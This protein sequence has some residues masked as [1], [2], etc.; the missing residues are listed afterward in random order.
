MSSIIVTPNMSLTLP[1]PGQELGPQY[2]ADNNGCFTTLDAHDHSSGSGVPI[3]PAGMNINIDLPMNNYNL[4]LVKTVRFGAL[5]SSLAGTT[6]NLGCL[7]VAGNELYYNDEAGNVVPITLNGSVNAG[8]GSITGLPSGT[9]SASYSAGTFVWRSATNTP[10]NMDGGSFIFRQV[11]ASA[12]GVTVSSPNSL[13][14]DYSLVWPAA[15]PGSTSFATIDTSGNIAASISTT[16]GITPAMVSTTAGLNPPGA[17]IM[18]GGA[19]APTGWLLCDG[20]SYLRATYA[21]LFTAIS[22]AYGTVDGTHFNV[23]DMRGMFARGVTGASANDPDAS[24]RTANNTG[25]ATGNNVGSQQ[26]DGVRAHTHNIGMFQPS[27]T[28]TPGGQ[29]AS[30]N[31]GGSPTAVTTV[32]QTPASTGD[33]RPLNVYVNYII[34]T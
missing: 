29:V 18:Y 23:P 28:F 24:S 26:A 11:S 5:I 17:I 1:I 25:G 7:Y 9:A 31:L 19:A 15:L 10:A 12:K 14:A 8:A 33:T 21:N 32:S 6:P 22:T 16:N 20:T 27:N 34:K 4:T 13:A 2:T 3:T 30:T